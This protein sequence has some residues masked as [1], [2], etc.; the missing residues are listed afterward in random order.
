MLGTHSTGK[1]TTLRRIEMELRGHGIAVAR[2]GGLG[3]RAREIGLPK[4]QHHTPD[5]TEWIISTGIANEIATRA[6]GIDVVL[7]DRASLDAL[8]YL[9]AAY[10][11][12]QE[13]LSRRDRE[14]LMLLASTQF[15]KYDLLLASVLDE[16]VPVAEQDAGHDYDARFRRL[17]D[18]HVHGLLEEERIQHLRVTSD[19]DSQERAIERAVQLCLQ[20]VDA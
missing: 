1:T 5:S 12:R 10:E 9:H 18:Q 8:A 20:V 17:V 4:M 16:N 15:P 2:I 11:Y 3:K 6:Q 19:A 14:R 7:V 13:H